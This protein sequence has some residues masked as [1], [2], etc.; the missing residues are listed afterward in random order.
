MEFQHVPDQLQVE[1]VVLDDED[2]RTHQ[3]S[4][5]R[6]LPGSTRSRRKASSKSSRPTGLTRYSTAPAARP[7]DFGDIEPHPN[8]GFHVKL[9]INAEGSQGADTKHKLSRSAGSFGAYSGRNLFWSRSS[10]PTSSRAGTA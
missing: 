7:R 10:R 9:T 5:S 6:L 8:Q 3:S 2:S 1:C 4:R